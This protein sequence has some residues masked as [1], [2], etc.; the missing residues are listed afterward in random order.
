MN[1]WDQEQS[2]SEYELLDDQD[3]LNNFVNNITT[4]PLMPVQQEIAKQIQEDSSFE[5][6]EE[7]VSVI[8][9]ARLRLEQ[10]KIYEALINSD[11]FSNMDVS[12]AAIDTVSAEIKNYVME[13]LE[14]LLGMKAPKPID[15]PGIELPIGQEEWNFLVQLAKKGVSG[16]NKGRPVND[17]PLIVEAKKTNQINP[18]TPKFGPVGKT[19]QINSISTKTTKPQLN[20][21]NNANNRIATKRKTNKKTTQSKKA[22]IDVVRKNI[23]SSNSIDKRELTQQEIDRIALEDIQNST[24]KDWTQM[25]PEERDKRITEVNN[26]YT[27]KTSIDKAPLPQP[28]QLEAHYANIQNQH[29]LRNNIS[30]GNSKNPFSTENLINMVLDKKTKGEM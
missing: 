25:T 24:N 3:N 27:R 15:I 22:P 30:G 23:N 2:I 11:L 28:E 8:H 7:D 10:A 21:A 12:Q 6:E 19:N 13:R 18:I 14:I 5:L 4:Q 20:N 16:A 29:R 17:S 9:N 1:I 26:K